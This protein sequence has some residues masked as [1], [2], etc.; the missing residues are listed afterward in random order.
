MVATLACEED[1][2]LSCGLR[3]LQQADLAGLRQAHRYGAFRAVAII[4]EGSKP[5]LVC[6]HQRC[7]QALAGVPETDRCACKSKTQ[8]EQDAKKS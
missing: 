3:C 2:V 5:A 1:Y 8:A 7:V 6:A 4:K